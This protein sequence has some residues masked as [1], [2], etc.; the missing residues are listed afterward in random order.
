MQLYDFSLARIETGQFVHAVIERDQIRG[1][2]GRE[3]GSVFYME[4]FGA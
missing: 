3:V 4:R 2:F 1:S